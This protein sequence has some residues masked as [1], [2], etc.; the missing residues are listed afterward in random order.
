MNKLTDALNVIIKDARIRAWLAE[1][2]PNALQQCLTALTAD[3]KPRVVVVVSGG[4]VQDIIT[5]IDMDVS[6]IDHD[7]IEAGDK[8]TT[9]DYAN[10]VDPSEIDKFYADPCGY[11]DVDQEE[12]A[13]GTKEHEHKFG[14]LERS[15]LA[16][17]AHRK[18][19]VDGCKVIDALDEDDE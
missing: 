9:G 17:T 11:C 16:G 7:N 18:C 15:R 19:T 4:A 10:T 8:P 12:E 5:D 1:N 2:D 6:L 13:D 14:P 3:E